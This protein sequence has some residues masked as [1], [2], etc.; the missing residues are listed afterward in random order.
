M[1]GFIRSK[2]KLKSILSYI[3]F[4]V[5]GFQYR[6]AGFIERYNSTPKIVSNRRTWAIR[7]GLSPY[8]KYKCWITT[9]AG[10]NIY[11][12]EDFVDDVILEDTL[13]RHKNLYFPEKLAYRF[14]DFVILDVGAHHGIYAAHA[15]KYYPSASLIAVEPNPSSVMLLK[16]N[17]SANRLMDRV[18]VVA[19]GIG[20]R[21]GTAFLRYGKSGSWGD[22]FDGCGNLYNSGIKVPILSVG[23]ILQ[24]HKPSLVKCNAEGAE[25]N[26]IP[27]LFYNGIFPEHIILM[28]HEEYG[29]VENLM[30]NIRNQG[31]SIEDVG[32]TTKRLRYHCILGN[33][34]ENSH[35]RRA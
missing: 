21:D 8:V 34:T 10:V 23:S 9:N 31:Y 19:A 32:S 25:F 28:A 13:I 27:Q 30:R 2:S 7:R 5:K 4:K 22:S 35:A 3:R 18:E 16:K 17:L 26:L 6:I 12:G 11:L 20:K 14:E 15:L 33:R 24:S 1:L 29:D